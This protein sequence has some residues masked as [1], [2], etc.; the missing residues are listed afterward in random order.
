LYSSSAKT[1]NGS[2]VK[3]VLAIF[4]KWNIKTMTEKAI[5]DY[6]QKAITEL[7]AIKMSESRKGTLLA[8]TDYLNK[9]EM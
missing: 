9:R 3:E 7:E 8:I 4:E 2:K 6:Q 5:M 1:D